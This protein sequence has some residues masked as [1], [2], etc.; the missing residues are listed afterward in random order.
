MTMQATEILK[1]GKLQRYY[2]MRFLQAG[3]LSYPD[4]VFFD[5]KYYDMLSPVEL[6]A[7]GAHEF[8]HI[9]EKHGVKRFT[10]IFGPTLAIAGIAGLITFADYEAINS[11]GIFSPYGSVL[12]SLFVVAL[13]L[14]LILIAS[15]YFNANWNRQQ[16]TQ[17]DLAAV[18]FANGEALISALVK[19]N[20]LHPLKMSRLETRILPKMYPSLEQR[21]ND[22]RLATET[23]SQKQ[24]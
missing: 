8:N 9:I 18:K 1:G 24:K 10:R 16:E 4:A 22:I 5:A 15:F 19:L 3:G 2:K 17:S 12:S 7:V 11:T 14:V 23:K 6:L 13:S 21:I 20:K